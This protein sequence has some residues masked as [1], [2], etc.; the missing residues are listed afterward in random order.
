MNFI[1]DFIE[2]AGKRPKAPALIYQDKIYSYGELINLI[3]KCGLAL[4]RTGVVPG[5][6]VA[7]M[8]NNRPEF[9]IAYQ[10]AVKV[11]ATIVPI[12]TFLKSDELLYQINDV[13]PKI[14]IGNDWAA[15]SAGPIKD[16]LESVKEFI[17]TAVDGY[18]DFNEFISSESGALELYDAADD[19]VAVIK[20]TAGTT[21]KPKGAMQSHANIYHFLR[22]NLDV[23]PVEP[24]QCLLLFVPLFHG[25][26]DHCCMNLVFMAGAR[27]LLMDPFKP[28][29]IFQAIQNHKC[30][31]FGCTPSMLY[32]LM[33]HPDVDKYD[34]SSLERVLTGGGP[35]TRDIV[36]GFGSK[37]G[38]EVLQ[39]YGLAEGTAGYT[40]TRLGM[41]FKE[42][43]CGISLPGAEITIVDKDGNKLPVGQ[44]GEVAVRSRYNMKG[45][46][47]NPEATKETIKDGWLHTGDVGKLDKDGYLYLLDRVKDM[48]IMS[49]ENIYPTEVEDVIL[50]H[51][52]VAQAAVIGAPDP[53]RG[54]VPCAVVVLN[55]GAAVSEDELIEYCNERLASFK[56]PKMVKFR[57]NMPLSAVFKVL[58]RELRKEYFG[59]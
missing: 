22:D 56:V 24:D 27:F 42:G 15:A 39:G 48:I 3:D 23:Q 37:F 54:E 11:G 18:T 52:A 45:Y 25:F 49:G 53:R 4:K 9:V 50:T 17:F 7:L 20:Y 59:T 46:W 36:E 14:F 58:K 55:P 43:S 35:V 21:G 44:V 1:K 2:Q 29:E 6:R 38:V 8:M 32:G 28:V 12:N 26:G 40:Y 34:L 57:E 41:P 10:A 47:N 5:D 13:R 33:N 30:I 31:Y 51:P 16:K 19:D